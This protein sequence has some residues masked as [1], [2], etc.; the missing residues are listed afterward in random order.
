MP[1]LCVEGG[2]ARPDPRCQNEVE[3]CHNLC[4]EPFCAR[5]SGVKISWTPNSASAKAGALRPWSCA[6][7][8]QPSSHRIADVIAHALI[9]DAQQES[10]PCRDHERDPFSRPAGVQPVQRRFKQP[11]RQFLRSIGG[12]LQRTVSNVRVA[13]AFGQLFCVG[14]DI[15][16][17]HRRHG[18]HQVLGP[19]SGDEPRDSGVAERAATVSRPATTPI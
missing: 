13:I 17:R 12:D 5:N 14:Q 11:R 19:Q 10:H 6:I 2:T 9:V 1:R 18:G 4:S 3:I 16:V 15:R 8:D 7:R